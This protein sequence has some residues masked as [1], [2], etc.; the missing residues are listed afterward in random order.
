MRGCCETY[1]VSVTREELSCVIGM[2]EVGKGLYAGL[3]RHSRSQEF[4]EESDD[5]RWRCG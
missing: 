5:G 2:V 3:D 1:D 4:F